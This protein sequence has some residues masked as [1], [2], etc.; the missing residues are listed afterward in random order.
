[1]ASYLN[2]TGASW[3]AQS[4]FALFALLFFSK[5][6]WSQTEAT[7]EEVLCQD[8]QTSFR[9]DISERGYVEADCVSETHAIEIDWN[10]KWLEGVGQ[11]LVYSD[12]TNK[13]LGLILVCKEGS[14]KEH[15]CYQHSL[16]AQQV[17]SDH[18]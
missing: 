7:E 3:I 6:S 1:M 17:I 11:A 15:L 13:R 16:M 5:P 4:L 18:R 14:D 9:I 10:H 2:G 12:L 8:M